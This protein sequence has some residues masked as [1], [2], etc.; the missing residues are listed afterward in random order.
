MAKK[1]QNKGLASMNQN[2]ELVAS[3]QEF[4]FTT[5]NV[6]RTLKALAQVSGRDRVNVFDLDQLRVPRGGTL[7][8]TSGGSVPTIEGVIIH[9]HPART[10]WSRAYDSGAVSPPDC[11]S[12][13]G[14]QGYGNPGV[15][16]AACPLSKFGS[17]GEKPA[18]RS[19]YR[20]YVLTPDS[21]LPTH[22]NVPVTS[23]ASVRNYLA[24]L[25]RTHGLFSYEVITQFSLE[26]TDASSAPT[27]RCEATSR[28]PDEMIDKLADYATK[29]R[30]SISQTHTQLTPALL[31]GEAGV[32]AAPPALFSEVDDEEDDIPAVP[33]PDTLNG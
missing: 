9:H 28:C 2:R 3:T 33:V 15:L 24:D 26:E 29:L 11:Y 21:V 13:D 6:D 12:P 16:C 30:E 7:W 8:K 20:V 1:S 4:R 19:A 5:A 17:K 25:A 23:I 10:Y 32:P 18:C 27:I 31:E 22:L 14:V